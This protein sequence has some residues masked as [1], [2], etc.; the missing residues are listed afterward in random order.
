MHIKDCNVMPLIFKL[1]THLKRIIQSFA[2][3]SSRI[4]FMLSTMISNKLPNR[5]KKTFLSLSHSGTGSHSK[6]KDF[7]RLNVSAKLHFR[8]VR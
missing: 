7:T 2:L 6:K 1:Q 4:A 5:F 8:N 3:L